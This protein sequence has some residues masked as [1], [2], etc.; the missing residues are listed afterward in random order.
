MTI[1]A[2]LPE[3]LGWE[4]VL[5]LPRARQIDLNRKVGLASGIN[6]EL[7]TPK[8]HFEPSAKRSGVSRTATQHYTR[9]LWFRSAERGRL[10]TV[11]SATDIPEDDPDRCRGAG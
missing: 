8:G 6:T 3:L 1:Q 10:T 11:I 7:R 4:Q 2:D 5:I 9:K